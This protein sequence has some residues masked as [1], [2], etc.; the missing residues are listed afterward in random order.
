MAILLNLVKSSTKPG[1]DSMIHENIT[2]TTRNETYFN[3]II[4]PLTETVVRVHKRMHFLTSETTMKFDYRSCNGLT[5]TEY[6]HNLYIKILS[7]LHT[8][9]GIAIGCARHWEG[10]I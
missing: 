9:N 5:S 7:Y 8:A 2:K 10:T 3:N 1:K 4:N 6:N